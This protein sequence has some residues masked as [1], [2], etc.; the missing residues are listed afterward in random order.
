MSTSEVTGME[1]SAFEWKIAKE[2]CKI[3]DWVEN[4][5][6]IHRAKNSSFQFFRGR[7]FVMLLDDRDRYHSIVKPQTDL[8]S[9]NDGNYESRP[10][11]DIFSTCD[12][13]NWYRTEIWT[14]ILLLFIDM[15]VAVPRLCIIIHG[16]SW[17]FNKYRIGTA[18]P[19][20]SSSKLK[21]KDC[22][23]VLFLLVQLDCLTV[24][25]IVLLCPRAAFASLTAQESGAPSI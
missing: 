13:F 3:F 8:R 16:N 6:K 11:P 17:R 9:K 21:Q 15:Q 14:L 10:Q 20:T 19:L 24:Q 4:I 1:K 12:S 7:N 23:R 25:M 18:I 5:P 2:N 22:L